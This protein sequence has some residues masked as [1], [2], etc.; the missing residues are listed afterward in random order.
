MRINADNK[1]VA[2]ADLLVRG[3]GE[4]VGGSQ[5]KKDWISLLSV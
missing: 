5:E 1:T 3:I 2:A 4:I